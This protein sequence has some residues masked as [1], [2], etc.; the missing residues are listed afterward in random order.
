MGFT[1]ATI[2]VILDVLAIASF[3][4]WSSCDRMN[5]NQLSTSYLLTHFIN[6]INIFKYPF[7]VLIASFMTVL[8]NGLLTFILGFV[9]SIFTED[10]DMGMSIACIIISIW[11]LSFAYSPMGFFWFISWPWIFAMP[12]QN[13]KLHQSFREFVFENRFYQLVCYG[14]KN[15]LKLERTVLDSFLITDFFMRTEGTRI[16]YQWE[17]LKAY[18]GAAT[19]EY[20]EEDDKLYVISWPNG[21][22][23]EPLR[24]LLED[25]NLDDQE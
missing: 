20:D 2:V 25:G 10:A 8:G 12:N 5:Y 9:I 11:G 16:G 7:Q 3:I 6:P 1:V 4:H 22:D 15:E 13:A 17:E 24:E 18:N 21:E 23:D 14:N 19:F